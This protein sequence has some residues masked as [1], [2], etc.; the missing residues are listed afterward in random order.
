VVFRKERQGKEFYAFLVQRLRF[1]TR[2]LAVDAALWHF[3]V[4]NLAGF[5][6]EALANVFGF[7]FSSA[8]S[9]R[10]ALASSPWAPRRCTSGCG[11]CGGD[12]GVS[13]AGPIDLRLRLAMLGAIK[14][15]EIFLLPH[16]GHDSCAPL[17]WRS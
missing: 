11:G 1:L 7:R 17:A 9:L 15:L 4:V 13:V 5:L 8:L 6:G 2:G 16:V 14:A 3:L 10:M 12:L